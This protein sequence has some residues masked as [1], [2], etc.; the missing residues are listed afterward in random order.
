[1]SELTL[2]AKLDNLDQVLG[3]VDKFLE[4]SDCPPKPQM[5]IDVAVE[6]LFVNIARYAYAP[7]TG[8]MTIRIEK[9]PEGV[10]I[11]LID[12]GVPFDP[13]AKLDPDVTLSAE[14]RQ[15]GGLGIFMVK[16]SMDSMEYKYEDGQNILTVRKNV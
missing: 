14:E 11:T 8:L 5:Q 4:E 7:N 15:I 13:V 16:K 10:S 12:R 6:E 2:E 1:M 9:D 3:F